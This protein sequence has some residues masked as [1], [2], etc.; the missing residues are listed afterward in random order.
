MLVCEGS[1]I[2]GKW[3]RSTGDASA[4]VISPFTEEP[5]GHATVATA[6]DVDRAVRSAQAAFERGEWRNAS[7]EERVSVVE[8]IAHPLSPEFA[9]ELSATIPLG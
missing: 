1:F 2:D 6:E 3:Q 5:F 8:A 4:V 7:L 9:E